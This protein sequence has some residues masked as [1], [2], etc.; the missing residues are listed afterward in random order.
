MDTPDPGTPSHYEL[1]RR[2]ALAA[3]AAA[4][5]YALAADP[6]LA[7]AIKTDDK[8]LVVG[9]VN[10]AGAD[11]TPIPVYEAYPDQAGEYPVIVVISEVWGLHEWI[12]D[13]VRRFGKEGYYAVAPELF[14]REGGLAQ[15]TDMQKVLSVVFNAPLKRVV[16]DL[17][18]GAEYARKQPAAR[19]D[20][21]GVTGFCWGGQM[22]LTFPAF[23]KDTKA[24][25]AWYGPPS[26]AHKDD[27][28]PI[29]AL[30]VAA[31]VPCPVLLLYGEA[32]Q[33]IPVADV[34]KEEAALK[35]AG[36]TVEKHVYPAAPHGFLADYRPSYR[37]DAAKDAWGKCLAW[38][39]KYLKA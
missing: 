36:R 15:V 1:S 31:E 29:A 23:Y 9:T 20:R 13:V 17:R 10:V 38:F 6:V 24:A 11:G 16:G 28:K 19:A 8:G 34:D 27:P 26:R 39:Q 35:A 37:A 25:V 7:Q 18:A 3:L 2:A 21:I 33:G 22:T 12:K 14:S 30:D 5:G 32:D 4:G